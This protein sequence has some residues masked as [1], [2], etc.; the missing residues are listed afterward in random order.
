MISTIILLLLE[1]EDSSLAE[2]G[3]DRPDRKARGYGKRKRKKP[4]KDEYESMFVSADTG[5]KE[6]LFTNTHSNCFALTASS[7][8]QFEYTESGEINYMDGE[9][10][11]TTEYI[12]SQD[13]V[14]YPVT[15]ARK[16]F[17]CQHCGVAFAREKA[18]ASH[19]RVHG[20]DSPFEC[21]TCGE[22][23][24]DLALMQVGAHFFLPKIK[25]N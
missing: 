16:P 23:F 15:D 3:F 13:E 9:A 22:M 2:D 25:L 1:E 19:A 11:N 18:L 4:A 14:K 17:V 10:E 20:G 7:S 21:Q 5:I 8:A 6:F 12:S 24:W